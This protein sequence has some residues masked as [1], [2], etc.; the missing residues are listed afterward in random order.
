MHFGRTVLV[1][2]VAGTI[3][4]GEASASCSTA[5]CIGKV[6]RLYVDSAGFF[7]DMEGDEMQMSPCTAVAGKYI[8]MLRSQSGYQDIYALMLTAHAQEKVVQV[9]V[10]PVAGDCKASYVVSDIP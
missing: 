10:Q 5:G 1:I 4:S 9:V 8:R 2:V 7:V 3:F 6:E